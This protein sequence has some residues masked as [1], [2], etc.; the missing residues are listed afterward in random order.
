MGTL[1]YVAKQTPFSA[2]ATAAVPINYGP[3]MG[4][5]NVD[6]VVELSVLYSNGALKAAFTTTRTDGVSGAIGSIN[7]LNALGIQYAIN[8]NWTVT[9]GAENVTVGALGDVGA[10]RQDRRSYV[11]GLYYKTGAHTFWGQYGSLTENAANAFNGKTTSQAVAGYKFAL[12]PKTS[13]EARYERTDDQA[14]I[15]GMPGSLVAAPGNTIRTRST[16][17]INYFF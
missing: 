16:I 1:P 12:D 5:Y 2:T 3:T 10:N 9:A 8:Q 4:D 17:G 11:A 15:V 6:G 13:I 7:T 14:G